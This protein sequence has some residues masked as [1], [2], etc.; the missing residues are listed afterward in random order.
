[1]LHKQEG[2]NLLEDIVAVIK[3]VCQEICCPKLQKGKYTGIF[4]DGHQICQSGNLL[5]EMGGICF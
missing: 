5:A 4:R 2:V 3:T 1:M